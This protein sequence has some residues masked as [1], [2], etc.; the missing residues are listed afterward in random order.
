MTDHPATKVRVTAIEPY[1][2]TKVRIMMEMI[3]DVHRL[4]E[5]GGDLLHAAIDHMKAEERAAKR[6]PSK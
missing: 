4:A 5:V 2:D 1:G 6:K 3:A